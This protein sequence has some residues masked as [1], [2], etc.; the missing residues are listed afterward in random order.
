MISTNRS[1][2]ELGGKRLSRWFFLFMMLLPALS[3]ASC[4]AQYDDGSVVG[5]I[6]DSSGAAVPNATVTVTN[7]ATG[8]AAVVKTDG[9]GDYEV[10]SLR[11]GTYVVSANATGYDTA[12]AKDIT[13]SVGGRERIDLSLK[14]GSTQ[15]TVE[16]SGVALELQTES[17]QHDQTITGYQTEALPLVSRNY[18]DLIDYVV[19]VRPDPSQVSQTGVTS[20]VRQGSYSVNGQRSMFN[21]YMIDGMDNN[22]YGESNQGF[23][24]Q[25]IQPP[26]D[27]IAQF[28]VVTNNESAEYGRSSGATINVATKS[29]TNQFHATLYEFN[30]NTD[31]NATGYFAPVKK[32]TFNRNQFGANFGGPILKNKF[33]W[34][35]DYEGFRQILTPLVVLTVPTTNELTGDLAV[36]VQDPWSPGTYVPSG[37]PFSNWPAQAQSDLDPTSKQIVTDYQNAL[38]QLPQCIHQQ[39][40][41]TGGSL[42]EYASDCATNAPF[43]DNSDKGDLRLDFQ[44]SPNTSWFLKVSD[45]KE[46]GINYPTLP[47]PID[48]QTNGLTK[49]HDEQIALGF[50]HALGSTRFLD[51]RLALS[52]TDAGKW[53]R[54]IGSSYNFG[55][56]IPGLPTI[57]DVSGGLPSI[58]INGGF[59]SFGRQSTNPQWQNP[60]LLDPKVNYSWVRNKH[61]LKF[62]YEYEHIWQE[63]EDSNPLYGSFAFNY[64]YSLCPASTGTSCPVTGS[65]AS[66]PTTTNSPATDTYWADFLFGA[67]RTYSLATYYI[68]HT[69]QTMNSAYAQDDWRVLP[70]LTLNLGLRWEYGGSWEARNGY[71]S[72][73]DPATGTMLTLEPSANYPTPAMCGT[74]PCVSTYSGGG[75]YGRQLVYPPLSDWAP[76][77]GFAFAATP[78]IAVRGGYGI[79]YVHYWRAGSGNNI[80]INA[81]FAMF[82]AVTNP[83]SVSTAGYY[84]LSSGFPTGLATTFS[85]GTDDI[86]YIPPH[87]ADGAAESWFLDVQ[88]RLAKNILFDVAYVGNHGTHLQGFINANQKNPANGF[89]RPYPNWGGYLLNNQTLYPTFNNGDITEALS[90]FHSSYN[91]LQ[92]RY[93]QQLVGGLTLL[94]SFSWQHALDNASST[95]DANTPCPQNGDDIEADYGQ[96]D[97]NLPIANVTTFVYDLPVGQGK[98]FMNTA[99]P[100]ANAVLGGWQ[101]SGVNTMQAGTPFNLT[102]SPAAANAV[103]PQLSQNWRGENLYRPN[104]TPG[105]SYISKTKLASGY[106]QYVN[107]SSLTLPSTYVDNTSA[108]GLASPFGDLP[109]NY[110]RTPAF[111]ET[112]LA[113]NKYFNTPVERAKI[114]FRAEFYN[115]F[116]HTNLYLPGGTGGGTVTGTDGGNVTGGSGGT[117]TTTF[118]PRI[119]QFALKV[120]Y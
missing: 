71:L 29:G 64:G 20:L 55:S 84:R 76:R 45:R 105:S 19:G 61:S 93:Q 94:N 49:I 98:M 85:A 102:Y 74:A 1:M 91:A 24:N 51:A 67:S 40:T 78:S 56:L 34:F 4:F 12:Q 13:V 101:V 115:V 68:A 107:L 79:A 62:G 5:T 18:S 114:E 26:P 25:I 109:K 104:L 77:I 117:I 82:T 39:G 80:A 8:V 75:L 47:E 52:G 65:Y 38:T 36:A 32:P 86:D 16:V 118:Q 10:P 44:Q 113:V 120:T 53:T 63:I 70:G 111:Y 110:G 9:A 72:N 87:T 23:D 112:D 66:A 42:G 50:N 100:V 14:V 83:S 73:F 2:A 57:A 54:A 96:S 15:T 48:G 95:L 35:V 3:G 6:H 116:N 69:T 43:T 27:S 119:I 106:I 108:D 97:Y 89:A 81:P 59:T 41:G 88:K 60:S 31:L 92:A 103:S 46:T 58:A 21:D 11:A 28:E 99:N 30:R 33:F 37:T 90:E 22:A 17:S 7:V